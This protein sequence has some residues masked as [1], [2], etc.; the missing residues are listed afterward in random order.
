MNP[1]TAPI[2]NSK[3]LI[4][5]NIANNVSNRSISSLSQV[6]LIWDEINERKEGRKQRRENYLEFSRAVPDSRTRGRGRALSIRVVQFLFLSSLMAVRIAVGHGATIR[7]AAT[8][9]NVGEREKG[10]RRERME[11]KRERGAGSRGC[12]ENGR[13]CTLAGRFLKIKWRPRRRS[14]DV[15]GD[16]E[17]KGEEGERAR[18]RERDTERGRGRRESERERERTT[19]ESPP[20]TAIRLTKQTARRSRPRRPMA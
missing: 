8:R 9:P 1:S 6:P 3:I 10:R 16:R 15:A 13:K 14:S 5:K 4:P 7:G 17:E 12:V 2:P 20:R 19:G 18:E 11:R